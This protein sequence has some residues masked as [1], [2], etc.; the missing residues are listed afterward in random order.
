MDS[1]ETPLTSKMGSALLTSTGTGIYVSAL[2]QQDRNF[3][4]LNKN[5]Q[6]AKAKGPIEEHLT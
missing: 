5:L 1:N 3:M 6:T 2:E 4:E